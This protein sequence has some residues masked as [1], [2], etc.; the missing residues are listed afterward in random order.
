VLSRRDRALARNRR[1][2]LGRPCYMACCRPAPRR[3]R[4]F[5]NEYDGAGNPVVKGTATL[6]PSTALLDVVDQMD[7][8]PWCPVQSFHAGGFPQVKLLATDNG[9]ISPQGWMWTLSFSGVPGNPSQRSFFLPYANGALQYL[10]SLTVAPF[11]LPITIT[12]LDGGSALSGAFP[13]GN[14]DGGSA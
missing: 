7:I 2:S 1:W 12:N 5:R 10:S 11:A 4:I 9:N 3:F 8:T 6:A 13:V 14:V